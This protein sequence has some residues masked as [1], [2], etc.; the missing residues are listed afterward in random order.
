MELLIVAVKFLHKRNYKKLIIFFNGWGMD[1]HP[2]LPLSTKGYDLLMVSDHST[3]L[4]TSFLL[5]TIADYDE[6]ILISWSMGVLAAQLVF[7]DNKEVFIRKIAINGTLCPVDD[8]FGIP[9][10]N[11]IS[12]L[13]E[14]DE[15][16]RMKF[17]GRMC[18]KRKVL[19]QFI[20][21]I[22]QRNIQNQKEEL[23]FYLQK[24]K[25]LTHESSI[26]DDVIVSSQDFVIPTSNQLRFWGEDRILI[27]EGPHFP[28]YGWRSWHD[29]V[30]CRYNI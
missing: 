27:V 8:K 1:E 7:Q 18:R 5:E 6:R 29:I 14:F 30:Q 19:T 10:D 28:F 25:C 2:F 4:D 22:P 11:Y 13:S 12:T 17:Y 26:Y 3:A 16:T 9:V 21:N 23:A 24:K 20:E 15:E